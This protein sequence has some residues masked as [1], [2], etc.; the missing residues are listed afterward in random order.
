MPSEFNNLIKSGNSYADKFHKL[1]K[2]NNADFATGVPCGVL[3][4]FIENFT[5][6]KSFIHLP[7]QNEP[8]TIGIASGAYLGGKNPI[9]YMQNSGMLKSTNEIGSL[10]IPYNIPILIIVTYRGCQGEDAPQHFITGKITKPTLEAM[11]IPYKELE[12]GN[13]GEIVLETY[14]A[15]KETQKPAIILVRRGSLHK[16]SELEKLE[17]NESDLKTWVT[18]DIQKITDMRH[19]KSMKREEALD[20][21]IAA[22][23]VDDAVL[24]STGLMSRSLYERHDSPNQFYTTGSFGLVSSIGLGFASAKPDKNTIIIDGDASILTNFGTLVTIGHYKPKNLIH[25]VLDNNSYASCSEEKS[26]SDTAN[27]PL[28]AALQGYS[29]VFITDTNYELQKAVERAKTLPGPNFIHAITKLGGR[30]D[31][32]RPKDLAYIARRFRNHFKE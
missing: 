28:I 31:F 16:D 18:E 20:A 26:C 11:N 8:E 32:K 29:H 13:I 27:F 1:L 25:I 6:D 22:T 4:Y 7:G 3:R 24:S 21:I 14:Q 19:N 12:E 17:S 5:K 15:M 2:E 30:R 9:V 23:K 10:L